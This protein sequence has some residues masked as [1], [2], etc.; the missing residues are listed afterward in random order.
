MLSAIAISA[1]NVRTRLAVGY[2]RIS[3][4]PL[5]EIW[6]SSRSNGARTAALTCRNPTSRGRR[7]SRR[8]CSSLGRT[9][10]RRRSS[11][12][13]TGACRNGEG[14]GRQA[15]GGARRSGGWWCFPW[16]QR[17]SERVVDESWKVR[18]V[19]GSAFWGQSPALLRDPCR[20]LGAGAEA[21]LG[22]DVRQGGRHRAVGKEEL[23][24]DV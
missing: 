24:G 9:T 15:S 11:G 23:V 6:M 2:R 12:P 13:Q 10:P 20:D 17:R 22:H 1:K 8:R 19:A 7:Q 21:E 3:R 16:P 4:L 18:K 14:L 5:G